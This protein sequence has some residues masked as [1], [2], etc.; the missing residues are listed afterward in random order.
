MQIFPRRGIRLDALS[1]VDPSDFH[2]FDKFDPLARQDRTLKFVEMSASRQIKRWTKEEDAILAEQCQ[3]QVEGWYRLCSSFDAIIA[4]PKRPLQ[5]LGT[6]DSQTFQNHRCFPVTASAFQLISRSLTR[7]LLASSGQQEVFF[8][9]NAIANALPHRNN[10][11]CRKRWYNVV[12]QEFKKGTW[13]PNEDTMLTSAVE[14][15]GTA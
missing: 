4:R 1:H 9:W 7:C 15:F 2:L 6:F 8:D 13:S 14:R 11:D 10:K 3:R 5:Q 12:S